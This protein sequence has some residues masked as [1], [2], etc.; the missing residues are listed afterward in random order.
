M[1]AD[2][3][4]PFGSRVSLRLGITITAPQPNSAFRVP[5]PPEASSIVAA[6]TIVILVGGATTEGMML[7]LRAALTTK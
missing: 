4:A 7:R 2:F 1:T 3:I 5:I 6:T